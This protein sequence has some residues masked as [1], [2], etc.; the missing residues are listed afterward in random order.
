VLPGFEELSREAASVFADLADRA[1]R[2]KG[3]FS[4]ALSGGSTPRRLYELLGTGEYL[5]WSRWPRVRVFF[6]DERCVPPSEERSNFRLARDVLFNKV[7]AEVHRVMGELAPGE[8]ARRY[9]EQMRDAFGIRGHAVPVF[10]LVLL[11][12]GADGHTASLFPGSPALGETGRLAAAVHE[13]EPPRVTLTLPVINNSEHVVFLVAGAEKAET[14]AAV[15]EGGEGGIKYPAG[16]VRPSS[17]GLV[18]LVDREAAK[19]LKAATG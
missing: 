10:D 11:G 16:L 19:N 18:W 17:G 8:A 15:L 2:T 3:R 9:E 12:M 1:I 14:L 13:K 4:V 5:P 6:S 7:E